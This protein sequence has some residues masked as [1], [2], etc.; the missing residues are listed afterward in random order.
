LDLERFKWWDF[1]FWDDT[2]IDLGIWNVRLKFTLGFLDCKIYFIY[3][4]YLSNQ[5]AAIKIR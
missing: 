5:Y 3:N 4:I 2:K 1:K